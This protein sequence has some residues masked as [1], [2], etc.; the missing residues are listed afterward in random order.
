MFTPETNGKIVVKLTDGDLTPFTEQLGYSR[1]AFD[2]IAGIDK[3]AAEN[4]IASLEVFMA[5]FAGRLTTSEAASV[6]PMLPVL[7][8]YIKNYYGKYA[9]FRNGILAVTDMLNAST[10]SVLITYESALESE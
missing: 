5:Q 3:W 9:S 6:N 10:N 1:G 4:S 8:N 7:G 2:I